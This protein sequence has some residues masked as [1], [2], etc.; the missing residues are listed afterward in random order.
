MLVLM[1]KAISRSEMVAAV[2]QN[3]KMRSYE[4]V[5]EPRCYTDVDGKL[6]GQRT[7]LDPTRCT[8]VAIVLRAHSLSLNRTVMLHINA[9]KAA[10]TRF[11]PRLR[12]ADARL[13][14]SSA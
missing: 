3:S 11:H 1:A 13:T 8:A 10:G 14:P 2:R 12:I 4:N 6:N 5:R 9:Q 7:W